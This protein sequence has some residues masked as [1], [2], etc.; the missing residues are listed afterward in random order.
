M[1]SRSPAAA[2]RTSIAP[3]PAASGAQ[4]RLKARHGRSKSAPPE[5]VP[6]QHPKLVSA[7]P[8]GPGWI[9][10][11]KFDGYR[12]QVRIEGGQAQWRSRNGNDWTARFA[13]MADLFAGLPDGILDGEVC[14]LDRQGRPDFSGLRS[15]L[16]RR[17]AGTLVGNLVYFVFDILFLDDEDLT[18]LP[19]AERKVRLR[20][21]IEP[22]GEPV[23]P[24]MRYVEV[25]DA[26]PRQLFVTACEM[27]LEGI[28]SKRM[29]AAYR[30][31]DRNDTWV[32]AKCRP[33]QE[34]VIGGWKMNGAKFRSLMAGVWEGDKLRYV[35]S[36]HT[37]YSQGNTGELVPRLRAAEAAASPFGLGDPPRKSS[38]IHWTRPELVARIE[39]EGWTPDGKVRQASYKGLREDKPVAEVVEEDP[40]PPPNAAIVVSR[41]APAPKKRPSARGPEFQLS[42][43]DKVLW[44]GTADHPAITKSDLGAYY[45]EAADWILPYVRGRPC[46]VLLAPDGIHGELFFQRHE[47]QKM[48]GLRDAAAVTHVDIPT[49][50]HVFP[51]FDSAEA[52]QAAVQSDAI[53][54]HPWNC[55]PGDPNLPGR[56]VFDLDPDEGLDFDRVIDAANELR[57]RLVRLGLTPFLKTSGGKGLHLVT[58]FLQDEEKPISWAEAK[59][60]AKGVCAA[61]AADTPDRYTIAL[62]K[63]QRRGRVFLDYLRTDQTRHAAGLLSPRATPEATV[64]MPLSWRDARRGLDPKA[65]T[66]ASALPLLRRRPVWRDYEAEAAPLRRSMARLAAAGG[67]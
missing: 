26:D 35:G 37:G 4:P 40:A 22:E 32:K 14:V 36:V 33:A 2:P 20:Q 5:F 57:D 49:L 25:I 23:S 62:P 12:M 54:L 42:H 31:G 55:V 8:L 51:Q 18:C 59:A 65:F 16:G 53:E 60:F 3:P 17:Q 11:V 48:G 43:E 64:S 19:L 45:A 1:P 66:L 6:F 21:I 9:H 24:R 61:M 15:A 29:D 34:V 63:A 27:G 52:L 46:T 38:E 39:F 44:P 41:P 67:G 10:E 30:P 56:F 28:V 47:G 13:D 50:E 58:P 7:P